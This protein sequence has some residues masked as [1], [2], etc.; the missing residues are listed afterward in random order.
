MFDELDDPNPPVPGPHERGQ[1]MTRAAEL[2]GRRRLLTGLGVAVAVA[3][4]ALVA[5]VMRNDS[6]GDVRTAAGTASSP[7]TPDAASDT[8]P[9]AGGT[10]TT[11]GASVLGTQFT[12]TTTTTIAAQP[13]AQTVITGPRSQPTS[14]SAGPRTN[15]TPGT[16]ATTSGPS[17]QPC[18]NSYSAACG[19]FRWDPDPGPNEDITAQFS[20]S[21]PNP[22]AG[23]QVSFR[24]VS[25]DVDAMP[26]G[27]CSANFGNG[28]FVCDPRPQVDPSFCK[29]QYGPWTP[30]A[31]QEGSNDETLTNTYTQPG[32]YDV[33]INVRSAAGE[34][35]NPYASTLQLTATVIVTP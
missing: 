8:T 1:V 15:A 10:A 7:S 9:S 32:T 4:I 11:I 13:S 28:G 12:N 21:P 22:R 30:P 33:T 34:C 17:T 2:V 14:P 18:R 26:V 3:L 35:N 23:E 5:G 6:G 16:T 20:Y 25:H 27:V 24:I 31:R 19:P 29:K